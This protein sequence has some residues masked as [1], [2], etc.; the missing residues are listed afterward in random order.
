MFPIFKREM[1]AYFSSP[2]GYIF[3]AVFL[4]IS[5]A[6]FS[7]FTVGS[8]STDSSGYFVFILF[9][10]TI[11]IPLLTMKL[12]SEERKMKTEQILLTSPV[13]I[14][15]MVFGKFLAA[16][17]VFFGTFALSCA[18]NFITLRQIAGK[19]LNFAGIFGNI[20]GILL[21]G[22]AFIS[23]GIFM[24]SLTENQLVSA[25]T[26]IGI[27]LFMLLIS[28]LPVYINSPTLREIVRFF[29]VVDRFSVFTGG[30]FS[31]SGISYFVSISIV[32]LFLTTRIYEMRRWN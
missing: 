1:R 21:I 23:I 26:T 12:F 27:I 20:V 19:P 3:M 11:L 7:V 8:S 22:A 31:L 28:F 17:T 16:F 30:V 2:I 25:V 5:G 32:F 15:G 4:A 9:V 6:I 10:F 24:S 29:S 18:V 13:S 14:F